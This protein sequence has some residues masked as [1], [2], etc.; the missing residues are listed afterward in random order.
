LREIRR[1]RLARLAGGQT[2]QPTTPLSTPLTSP[3]RE[4]PPGP[5]QASAPGLGLNVHAMT[6]ATSPIGAT[7]VAFRSQSSEGVSSLSSSPSNSL[8]TQSQTLSRS[9]S[10][11]IDTVACEKSMSLVDVDSGIENMEVEESDRRE[12]RSLSDKDSS[13]SPDVTEE[14]ALQLVCKILRVSW[15]ERSRDVIFLPSLATEFHQSP[16]QVFSDIKDLIG[17]ILMEVLMMSSQCRENNPFASLTATSLPIVA[18]RSPDRHLSLVPPSGQACNPMLG[19]VGSFGSS[20]PCRSVSFYDN[21]LSLLFFTLSDQSEDSSE[22]EPEEEDTFARV[23]F[24]LGNSGGGVASDSTS[25]RFTIEAC[26]ETEMLNYLIERFD[27]VGM[28]ERKAPK[29]CS[30]PLVS[31]LLSNI[32]SQCISHAVLVLQGALTQPRSL[33]QHS[34]LVPYMLCRNLP[35]GFIQEL[36]RMTHQEDEVFKQIFIPILQGLAQAVKECS[37]NSDS[38]KYPLMALTELCEIKYGKT[39][40]VCNLM[41]SMPL[42]C[43]EPLSTATGR[44]VQRLSYL[45]S[46]FSLSVFAEDDTKVGDKYFSG[47]TITLENTRVVSQSLQHYL[48]SARGDLFKILHSVLLNGETR[49]AALNYMAA[50]VNRN[51]RKAQMQTDDKLVSTDGFMLNFLWVL[52]QLSMKIKLE[53]VDPNYIFHPR[54]RL[55]IPVEETRLKASM[56][57]LK[58]WLA[59]FHDDPSKF[60]EPKFPTECFFL[61]LHAHH[62]SILPC[63][64]RYIRRLRAIRELNRT[65]EELKNSENQWKDSPLAPR[66]REMLK[67]CKAQ[68]KKLVR[69][70]A[71]ADVG[72]LDENLLRRCLQFYSMV[73]QLVLRIVDPAY[74]DINLPLNPEVPRGFAAL[75][76]FYVEDVAEFILFIVQYFPQVL[77]EPCTQDV[78]TFLVVFIC[79]ENYIRNPYLIAKLVEVLFVTNPAVQPRTHRFSEMMENHPLAVKQLVPALMKFYTDV[80]HTGATSEFYDKFTIRYHISTIFKSL[81]QNIGHHGTFLK[82]FNSGKQ[83]VRYINMLINDTTFL[84]DESLE[85]LKRIHEVQEEMKSKDQWDQMS[86]EQQQSR[87][88]QLAQDERVSRSYLAL[89]TET[90]DMFHLL[91]KQVQKPFLRPELGPRLAAMLNFNLQQLCGPKCRDL[92]VENP[93]KYGFEPKK[94]L[95]QLTDI[96]LQLDCARFAKAIADDQRSYSREL[97]E[98]VISKMRK[99]GIKSTIAIEKFKLLSE[100][101]EEIVARNSQSEID[102]S[103]APDEFKDPLMDTLMS[104][105]VKLPSGNIMDRAVILRHLL[106]SPTDPFNRQPLTESM[107]ESVPALKDRI[108]AWMK[109]KQ[110]G[111]NS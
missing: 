47:P 78:V 37:F 2:S 35:Y 71:C 38:F 85:S 46:F 1:R 93:E 76:E 52:Q 81:W 42:W 14:Q 51:V 105:P 18:A 84:L 110:G 104:D 8:D 40:P 23:T 32:R 4:T 25:D 31:Q 87:Q 34:L 19:P 55:S 65:V 99:A 6:S 44:E 108:Q 58:T 62:L 21:P 77:Y 5:L 74:P 29:V 111:R 22:D 91:T 17:Q 50:V 103:D 41:M 82:E 61:T 10:M 7:G 97:F 13:P 16:R 88:S 27:S 20:S 100:K 102:Y 60:S 3:Q 43:P 90:V 45:G 64:R 75:P 67:R 80:E 26:K 98:E 36:V 28:E 12:K 106:N 83:F 15:K 95:D 39:H 24:G 59:D 70:K 73:I 72:L 79:S 53:T 11:D 66:H 56:E 86:R 57:E 49:E 92:K 30:Q 48:E 96:Y 63:C 101:V 9:Q 89:A 107:L 68:L 109:E 54:C 33:L 94:L 69:C